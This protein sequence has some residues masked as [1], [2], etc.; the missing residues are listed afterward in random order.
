MLVNKNEPDL[1]DGWI[2]ARRSIEA[3]GASAIIGPL[4]NTINLLLEYK[5]TPLNYHVWNTHIDG[6]KF[7]LNDLNSS[8]KTVINTFLD[9]VNSVDADR[10]E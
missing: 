6:D 4:G 7:I 8:P 10:A 9:R 3:K 5:W 2:A 1:R